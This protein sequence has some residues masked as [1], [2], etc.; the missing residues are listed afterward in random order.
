MKQK[1]KNKN[2]KYRMSY[3]LE[4]KDVLLVLIIIGVV[5]LIAYFCEV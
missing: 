3:R 2:G 4:L 1:I 5:C